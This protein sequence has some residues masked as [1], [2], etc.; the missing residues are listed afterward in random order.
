MYKNRAA[1]CF[2]KVLFFGHVGGNEGE[3]AGKSELGHVGEKS[4][5]GRRRILGTRAV[6][7][8]GARRFAWGGAA[9]EVRLNSSYCNVN[10]GGPLARAVLAGGEFVLQKP[11]RVVFG[12]SAILQYR[13]PIDYNNSNQG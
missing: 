10:H 5:Y 8:G 13:Q 7:R 11:R 4:V 1:F 6:R 9:F 3:D 12:K 2:A